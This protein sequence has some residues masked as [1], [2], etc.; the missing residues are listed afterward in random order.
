MNMVQTVVPW[1]SGL[2]FQSQTWLKVSPL[3]SSVYFHFQTETNTD[4]YIDM[5][6]NIFWQLYNIDDN[7]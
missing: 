3:F 2:T 7:I 5:S 1:N 6:N 4:E